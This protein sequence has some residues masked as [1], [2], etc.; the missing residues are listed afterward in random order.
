[1]E[2]FGWG[3]KNTADVN[4]KGEILTYAEAFTTDYDAAL[5]GNANTLDIDG[6]N[7]RAVNLYLVVMENSHA[8][9]DMVK[10]YSI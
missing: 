10:N 6:V 7:T 5:E 3:K 2:I 8:T 4:E 1:M 9:K